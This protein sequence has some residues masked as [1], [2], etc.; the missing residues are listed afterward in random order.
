MIDRILLDLLQLSF[1]LHYNFNNILSQGI[2][3]DVRFKSDS[4]FAMRGCTG[5]YFNRS[6]EQYLM[7]Y[8]V[9]VTKKK[10]L[11][12][13]VHISFPSCSIYYG[14][15]PY[16]ITHT[17]AYFSEYWYLLLLILVFSIGLEVSNICRLRR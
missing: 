16:P 5:S 11:P 6:I 12:L 9:S 3:M 1:V 13:L 7:I 14:I 17:S 10:V 2:G 8:Q 15:C 4:I